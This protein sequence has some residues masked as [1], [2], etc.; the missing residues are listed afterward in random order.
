MG[1]Q[2]KL[3]KKLTLLNKKSEVRNLE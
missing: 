2:Q 1:N 3:K